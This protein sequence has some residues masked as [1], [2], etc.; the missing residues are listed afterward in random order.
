MCMCLCARAGPR[1]VRHMPDCSCRINIARPAGRQRPKPAGTACAQIIRILVR[2]YIITCNRSMAFAQ[3][4]TPFR[5]VK[6]DGEAQ[7][8]SELG[9]F[10][11]TICVCVC[12]CVCYAHTSTPSCQSCPH[13]ERLTSDKCYYNCVQLKYQ[14]PRSEF[15]CTAAYN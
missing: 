13:A 7:S 8:G 2:P 15:D 1:V 9:G 10:G 6:I 12:D 3:M 11:V 5:R 4:R 14:T